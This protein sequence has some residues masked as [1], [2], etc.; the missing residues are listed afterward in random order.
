MPLGQAIAKNK[1]PGQFFC[2]PPVVNQIEISP[3]HVPRETIDWC[4]AHGMVVQAHSALTKHR[5]ANH[6]AVTACA[7]NL[8][9]TPAQALLVWHRERGRGRWFTVVSTHGAK[10]VLQ[11]WATLAKQ[12]DAKAIEIAIAPLCAPELA[13][14]AWVTHP[15]CIA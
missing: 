4:L 15:Q 5:Q 14:M 2:F 10:H 8:C 6:A 1:E 7:A 12:A 3:F 11:N 13:L 9:C